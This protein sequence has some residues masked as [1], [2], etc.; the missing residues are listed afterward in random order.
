M[1]N[2]EGIFIKGW[3][4]VVDFFYDP[5]LVPCLTS[6]SDLLS[7]YMHVFFFWHFLLK[8]QDVGVLVLREVDLR[9]VHPI[10]AENC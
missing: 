7:P 2:T 4:S 6:S 3:E 10:E 1:I 5:S 8:N 9:C